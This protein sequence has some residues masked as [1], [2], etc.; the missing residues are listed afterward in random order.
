MVR[1]YDVQSAVIT[2]LKSDPAQIVVS[3]S[4]RTSSTGWTNPTLGAWYYFDVPKDGIQDFD[5]TADEPTG[6]SLP[7]LTPVSADAAITRDPANY[8]GKGKPLTGV[9]I[10]AR[11]N[12]IEQKLDGRS[13]LFDPIGEA[14]P[15][16]WPFP[17]KRLQKLSAPSTGRLADSDNPLGRQLRVYNSGDGLTKDY[18]PDRYNVELSP[19]TERIVSVWYG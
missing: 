15:L 1:I 17:W 7:V 11:T 13:E 4:G 6:I 5:C 2:I 16:P 3:A 19:S 12:T 14:L 10:H 18:R 9:R 8:W